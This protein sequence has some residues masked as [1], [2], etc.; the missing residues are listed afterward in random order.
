ME[1]DYAIENEDALTHGVTV[2]ECQDR[3]RKIY[4]D[5]LLTEKNSGRLS[6]NYFDE[7]VE[8]YL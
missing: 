7:L 8:G 6:Q 3:Y 1:I 5:Y 2:M 4:F